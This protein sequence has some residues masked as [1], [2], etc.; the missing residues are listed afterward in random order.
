M[1]VKPALAIADWPIDWSAQLSSGETISTSEWTISPAES[2]GL[3]VKSGSM[4][5]T[6]A[7]ASCLVEGGLPGHV[8]ELTNAIVTSTGRKYC[9]TVTI[10]VGNLEAVQ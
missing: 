7:I 8:Y 2:G 9:R 4:A 3:S 10:V 6:D 5:I 1:Q